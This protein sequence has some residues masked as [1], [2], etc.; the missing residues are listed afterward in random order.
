MPNAPKRR[1]LD[2]SVNE[3]SIVDSPANEQMF[4]VIKNLN[5]EVNNMPGTKEV[6]KNA[7]EVEKNDSQEPTKVA[8]ETNP[9]TDEAVAKAMEQVSNLIENISKSFN[10]EPPNT[11]SN[12]AKSD[13]SEVNK[14]EKNVEESKEADTQKNDDESSVEENTLSIL[15]AAIEKAKSFTPKRQAAFKA[16]M[17]VLN[18]LAKELGMQEIPVGSFPATNT[19]SGTSFGASS[20]S[21]SLEE[22]TGTVTKALGD[23][24]EV[25]K[26]LN[27]R[28]GK[29]EKMSV[30][31]KSVEGE[32]GTDSQVTK[33]VSIWKGVI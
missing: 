16:A 8:V 12:E 18:N 28:I 5:E 21:K 17:E 27:E 14:N 15:S 9:A 1:F 2:L 4:V 11:P 19:P 25:T 33:N 24:T 26:G 10:Q 32:G 7:T 13:E 31:S 30:P 22:F 20:I 23:L 6:E 3:V 29:V